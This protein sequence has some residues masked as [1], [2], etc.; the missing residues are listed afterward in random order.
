MRIDLETKTG[1]EVER[2]LVPA[3]VGTLTGG[4]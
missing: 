1:E 2:L 3:L 4:L